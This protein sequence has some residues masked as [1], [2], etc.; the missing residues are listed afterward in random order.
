MPDVPS[1]HNPRLLDAV[2]PGVPDIVAAIRRIAS[3]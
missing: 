3:A 2:V 1:P